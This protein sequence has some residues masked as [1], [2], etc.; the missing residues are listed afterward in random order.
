MP[1]SLVPQIFYDLIARVVP[2]LVI[3]IAWYMAV[4]GPDRAIATISKNQNILD[5]WAFALLVT[6]SYILG[7]ILDELW[8]LTFKRIKRKIIKGKKEGYIRS[9]IDENNKVRERFGESK[10]EF[11]D[12]DLPSVYAMHDHLRLYSD[13]EAYRLLK[14]RAE[15][16]LCEALFI[17]FLFLPIVNILFWLNNS[18]LF[19]LDRA[20]LE[21]VVILAILTFWRGSNRFENF[22]I[23]GT[24]RSWLFYNFPVGPLKQTKVS[25]DKSK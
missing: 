14:V 2:G 16:R 10:I 13:S 11:E 24:C 17:G 21:L 23:I 6:L 25:E 19:I 18:R 4:L 7:F 12:K 1:L 3:V 9:C 5:F 15:A 8:S 20:V 22:Y